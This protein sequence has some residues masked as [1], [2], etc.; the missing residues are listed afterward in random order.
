MVEL[1][2]TGQRGI[3]DTVLDAAGDCVLAYGVRRTTVT[4]VARRAGVSRMTV[5]RRWPDVQS[6][7]GDLMTREWQRVLLATAADE[8]DGHARS[9]LVARVVAG[10]RVMREHPLLC[11]IRDVDPEVLIPYL[12]DRRGAGQEDMLRFL[13]AAV[14]DGAADGSVRP[15]DAEVMARMVFLTTQSFVLS[16]RTV[17]DGVSFASFDRELARLVDGYLRP[18]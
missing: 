15:G 9:R 18:D 5:Y 7:I 16:A 17:V 6:M 12:F 8:G 11:K 14:A 10:A 13:V 2:R 1:S 3:E 4:D